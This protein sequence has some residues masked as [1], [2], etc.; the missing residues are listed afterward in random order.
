MAIMSHGMTGI[1]GA[2]GLMQMK[3]IAAMHLPATL[4]NFL[5]LE[6]LADN[7]PQRY[8][9]VSGQPIIEGSVIVVPDAP[10]LGV[11]LLEEVISRYR[12][13]GD[14]APPDS[15]VSLR[16]SSRGSTPMVEQPQS[17]E[18]TARVTY[19]EGEGL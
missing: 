19:S 10:D 14:I 16:A 15:R 4:P 18:S 17:R 9:V 11:D 2:G 8:E 13:R 6:H 3:K 12:S 1:V 5:I 7:V